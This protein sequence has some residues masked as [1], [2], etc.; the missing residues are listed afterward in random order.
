MSSH[1]T[2]PIHIQVRDV[3]HNLI[4][5]VTIKVIQRKSG[6]ILYNEKSPSGEVILD[7]IENLKDCHAFRV[8]IEHPH[9]KSKPKTNAPCIRLAN[10]HKPHTLEFHYQDKL[11]VSNVSA[12]CKDSET[13]NNTTKELESHTPITIHLKAYYNQDTIPNKD[14][15]SERQRQTYQ[16]QKTQTKWGYILF[17]KDKDIDSTLKELTKDSTIPITELKEFHRITK[18]DSM[19][20][21]AINNANRESYTPYI[22]QDNANRT[23]TESQTNTPHIQHNQTSIGSKSTNNTN[24]D[25]NAIES[26]AYLLGEE[27]DI[28]Y[29]EEWQDKQVRFFAYIES[30]KSDVGVDVEINKEEFI[31]VDFKESSID[32]LDYTPLRIFAFRKVG[33][34]GENPTKTITSLPLKARN[35]STLYKVII[36]FKNRFKKTTIRIYAFLTKQKPRDLILKRVKQNNLRKT[37]EELFRKK[38]TKGDGG[39]ADMLRIEFNDL[40]RRRLSK[41]EMIQNFKHRTKAKQRIKNLE[42]LLKKHKKGQIKLSDDEIRLIQEL[43]QDLYDALKNL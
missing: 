23:N 28:Y 32:L 15:Q 40:L 27:I 1:N 33:R 8:E 26:K 2:K 11:L 25:S 7:D 10:L 9:Y 43:A 42:N 36:R 34:L 12:E 31:V 16:I 14:T 39:T 18:E 35:V 17:D 3:N 30:A 5:N 24:K 37:V 20:N 13:T 41:R 21:K 29:K 19:A 4:E 22:I 38:A 6:K